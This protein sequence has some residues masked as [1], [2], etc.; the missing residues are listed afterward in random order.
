M[1]F[2]VLNTLFFSDRMNY[3]QSYIGHG[4]KELTMLPTPEGEF[5]MSHQHLHIWPKHT[6]MMIALPNK[7]P[8]HPDC[9]SCD[10]KSTFFLFPF[11]FSLLQDKTFTCTLFMPYEKF[12]EIK[13]ETQLIAFF[14]SHFP[15][16]IP[17]FG[18]DHLIKNYFEN[19]MGSLMSVKVSL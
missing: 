6:F 4:Y 7:V 19:P 12:D 10:R 17:L 11:L 14:E 2:G 15:D 5:R 9:R 16:A 8:Y 1:L 13:T 18:H 3:S